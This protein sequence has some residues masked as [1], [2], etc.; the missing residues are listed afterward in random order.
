M[1]SYYS[2]HLL[3]MY[4]CQ[5]HKFT[6]VLPFQHQSFSL[7]HPPVRSQ[8]LPPAYLLQDEWSK[9]QNNKKQLDF[10]AANTLYNANNSPLC[11]SVWLGGTKQFHSLHLS[12]GS[13][14]VLP[15]IMSLRCSAILKCG[16]LIPTCNLILMY[17]CLMHHLN[18]I[19][20][21]TSW[22]VQW[23]KMLKCQ[24]SHRAAHFIG[25]KLKQIC[26]L[27]RGQVS[28]PSGKEQ[29]LCA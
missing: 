10:G 26:F 3:N 18:T 13:M 24:A 28:I 12:V 9:L 20:N 22:V 19:F 27:E 8:R 2:F 21:R 17:P 5:T 4:Q 15:A 7:P 25:P 29:Q 14:L 23:L 11:L 16:S 1:R 6:N